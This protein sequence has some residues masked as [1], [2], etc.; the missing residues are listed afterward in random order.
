M[1][2]GAMFIALWF[3]LPFLDAAANQTQ[4]FTSDTQYSNYFIDSME[5]EHQA[6]FVSVCVVRSYNGEED[7][8][9]IVFFPMKNKGEFLFTDKNH[10]VLNSGDVEWDPDGQWDMGNLEGGVYTIMVMSDLFYKLTRLPFSWASPKDVKRMLAA[11]P[12]NSCTLLKG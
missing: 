2:V 6:A 3:C 1:R 12:H 10:V 5:K 9:A 7:Q 8:A 4:T 11:Q